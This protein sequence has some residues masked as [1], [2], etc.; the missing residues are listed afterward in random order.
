MDSKAGWRIVDEQRTATADL[1]E[2]LSPTQWTA[3]SLCPD[4]T[5][6]DVAAHLSIVAGSSTRELLT[7]V[8]HARGNVNRMI[9]TTALARAAARTDAQIVADLRATVGSRRLVPMTF[10]RDPLLDILVH[11]QDIARPLGRTSTMPVEAAREAAGWAWRR[12]FPFAP[13][14]QLRGVRLVA[15]D[16]DW[17]RGRGD[18]VTGPIGSLLLLSTG[19]RAVLDDLHG[20]GLERLTS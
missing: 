9:R 11:G 1:L 14:R 10:W 17:G 15:D 4:W 12:G 16:T 2:T 6:R 3:P 13:R 18:L 8:V 7:A 19:R 20:P 5:V